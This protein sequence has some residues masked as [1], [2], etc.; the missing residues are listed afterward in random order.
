MGLLRRHPRERHQKGF[1]FSWTVILC[2]LRSAGLANETQEQATSL[3]VYR[4]FA[5]LGRMTDDRF[6]VRLERRISMAA[7]WHILES[8]HLRKTYFDVILFRLGNGVVRL[9]KVGSE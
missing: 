5:E 3:Q 2:L 6:E 4:R 1:F 7:M 9:R 8:K